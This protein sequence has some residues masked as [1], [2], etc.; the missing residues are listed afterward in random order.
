M[1]ARASATTAV[2]PSSLSLAAGGSLTDPAL[3]P[4]GHLYCQS[5]TDFQALM[6]RQGEGN[7]GYDV[8]P[9]C[10]YCLHNLNSK[11]PAPCA[12]ALSPRTHALLV[13]LRRI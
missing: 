9:V 13:R 5:C 6:P 7:A 1:P 10:G 3:C 4:T 2:R 11:C 12:A 8:V